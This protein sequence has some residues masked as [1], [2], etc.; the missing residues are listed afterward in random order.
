VYVNRRSKQKSTDAVSSLAALKNQIIK[1]EVIAMGRNVDPW[2]TA[3]RKRAGEVFKMKL[4]LIAS[5][6]SDGS[7]SDAL[8]RYE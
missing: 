1:A 2:P 6:R 3:E 8:V 4:S 5:E 7:A